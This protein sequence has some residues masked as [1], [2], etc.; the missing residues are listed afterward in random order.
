[1][2]VCIILQE[3]IITSRVDWVTGHHHNH[4]NNHRHPGE[5]NSL[6]STKELR[7]VSEEIFDKLPIGI[8]HSVIINYQGQRD[9]KDAKDEAPEP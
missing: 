4:N 6:I 1:M 5:K 3:P 2:H 8:Y 7:K 9:S